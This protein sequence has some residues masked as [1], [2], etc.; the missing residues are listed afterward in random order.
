MDAIY[1]PPDLAEFVTAAVSRGAPRS[2][3][4]FAAG[5]GA[6]L[7][8]AAARW[9][10][11]SLFG[12]D[13]DLQAVQTIKSLVPGCISAQHDFLAKSSDGALTGRSFDLILLNPPFSNRGNTRHTV[14][15]NGVTH[16]ASK[17]LA[18][19]ARALRFLAPGGEI[20]AILPASVM[21]SE[22]DA[23]LLAALEDSGSV[24]QIG[25]IR[26]A[27]FKS[28][29]VAVVVL[30]MSRKRV[31][32]CPKEKPVLVSLRPFSVEISRGSVSMHEYVAAVAGP[33]FIHTT[34]MR[35]GILLPSERRAAG[36]LRRVQGPAVLISRV[37]RPARGKIVL[38]PDH[39][40]V[41]SD[42]I[43]AMRTF[44]TG[45]E[46]ELFELLA[47]NWDTVKS[48]YGGSCAPYTTLKRLAA[49]LLRLGISSSLVTAGSARVSDEKGKSLLSAGAANVES[50]RIGGTG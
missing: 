25:D 5:D 8:A 38:L 7:R 29:A 39:E 41:L 9:P 17:A 36:E 48:A 47:A 42:C 32:K 15:I 23:A 19:A 31:A 28:H 27:A 4:D 18:F 35:G 1:T 12:S 49:A 21:V 33:R 24:E 50:V 6:L 11:A 2:I 10:D 3:A 37:G 13:V 40:A 30:R 45:R 22:R 20:V 26:R 16:H 46:A 34:D 43:I 44:P 14:E